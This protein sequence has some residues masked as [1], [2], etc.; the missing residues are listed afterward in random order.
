MLKQLIF[1]TLPGSHG[2]MGGV[3][4]VGGVGV[5][6]VGRHT[7]QGLQGGVGTPHPAPPVGL[8]RPEQGVR[9]A[10]HSAAAAEVGAV[11]MLL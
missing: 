7:G 3:L 1:P 6:Q 10:V 5:A 9:Q 4:V 8:L 2:W 11:L